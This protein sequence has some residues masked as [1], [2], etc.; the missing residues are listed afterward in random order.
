MCGI[1]GIFIGSNPEGSDLALEEVCRNMTD[2]LEHRGPDSEGFWTSGSLALGHRRLAIQDLT[3]CGYQPMTSKSQ[4]YVLV[5][6]GEIYN[7]LDI[8]K[9]LER[10][11][12][13]FNGHSDT[14]VLL[15]AIQCWGLQTSLQRI[16]GMFAF[17]LWDKQEQSLTLVQDKLGKKPLYFGYVGKHFVFASELKALERHPYFRFDVNRDALALYFRYNYVPSPYSIFNNIFKLPQGA[18]I[19]LRSSQVDNRDNLLA[20]I[21]CYWSPYHE[22]RGQQDNLFQGTFEQASVELEN[23]LLDSI[24]IRMISDVPVG[25]MLSGGIDSTT[26]AALA[27]TQSNRPISTF[28]LGF[29]DHATSEAAAAKKI[30]QHINSE[31]YELYISGED[32][33]AVLP[34]MPRIYDEP[35]GDSSQI[36]TYIVSK[37]ARSQVTVA[38][39]GDGGDELFYGY[40]RYLSANKIW[41]FNRKFPHFFRQGIAN[42]LRVIGNQTLI[43]GKL[44]KHASDLRADHAIESYVSRVT[45]FMETGRLVIDSNEPSL[46]QFASIKAQNIGSPELNMM[47]FDFTT[48]LC[49]DILVK[50]DRAAMATSLELRNPL[51]DHRIVK[52]AWQLPIQFNYQ[53]GQG[54]YV[55]RD[56]LSRYVPHHLTNRPKQG[57]APPIRQWLSG[58][59]IDWAEDLLA[60]RRIRE[61]GYLDSKLVSA[62][63]QQCKRNPK[64]SHSRLWTIL[65]FQAWLDRHA[66]K[67]NT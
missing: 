18:Y 3:R 66:C 67:G 65:M 23:L 58:P 44:L 36:P 64:K 62:L 37:L 5:Y 21:D 30:A 15:A 28:S 27:Q 43:E 7:F 32:A 60:E 47:L 39:T 17:A 26:V 34:E 10:Q 57:F 8:K 63:W 46:D 35:F 20:S 49:D 9:E 12:F 59:L 11:G 33:L 13:G 31:H 51:L 52:F 54:K 56:L 2:S 25:I 38:L 55:L 61:E 45:K 14:E 41:K 4:R 42:T 29:S 50:V 53:N 24:K 16:N 48:F 19:S 22:A 1:A 6:N 40:K